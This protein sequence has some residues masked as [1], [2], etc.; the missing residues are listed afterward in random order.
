[1]LHHLWRVWVQLFFLNEPRTV[2]L[3]PVVRDALRASWGAILMEYE[4]L[5]VCMTAMSMVV[6]S[7]ICSKGPFPSLYPHLS[8]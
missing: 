5:A 2:R 7:I 6:T 3:Q 4:V 8:T 1:M